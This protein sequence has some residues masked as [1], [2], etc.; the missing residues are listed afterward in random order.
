MNKLLMLMLG[1]LV[2]SAVILGVG[3]GDDDDVAASAAP[4]AFVDVYVVVE[5]ECYLSVDIFI[6]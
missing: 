6:V 5:P 1:V 2:L 3:C 4:P